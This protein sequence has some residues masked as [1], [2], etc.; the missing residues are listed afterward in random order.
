VEKTQLVL[1]LFPFIFFFYINLF[2]SQNLQTCIAMLVA[3]HVGF[4]NLILEA[5][6][7]DWNVGSPSW[8]V[9]AQLCA[10]RHQPLFRALPV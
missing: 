7:G 6:R 4:D 1:H 3:L 2:H 9:D 10:R 5:D 8:S